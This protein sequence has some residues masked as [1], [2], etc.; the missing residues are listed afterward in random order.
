[1]LFS[2]SHLALSVRNVDTSN[3]FYQKVFQFKEMENTASKSRTHWLSIGNVRQLHFIP[4]SDAEI[5]T[6]KAVHIAF[7]TANFDIVIKLLN[8]LNITYYDWLGT[9]EKHY[10]RDDGIEQIYFQ[11]PRFLLNQC[12]Q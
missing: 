7:S 3:D 4:R 2:F 12:K 10:V 1:M 11:D 8:E 9:P 5:K 6:N